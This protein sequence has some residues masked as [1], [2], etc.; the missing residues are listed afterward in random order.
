MVIDVLSASQGRLVVIDGD[1]RLHPAQGEPLDVIADALFTVVVVWDFESSSWT[2][3]LAT[4]NRRTACFG[5]TDLE[6]PVFQ[7]WLR[8]LPGWR[9]TNLQ[10]ATT[11]EG[12]HLVWRRA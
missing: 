5:P 4:L 11:N 8:A 3:W 10:H 6:D 12:L 9:P 1:G 2:G 7:T